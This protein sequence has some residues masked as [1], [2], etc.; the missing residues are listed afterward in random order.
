VTE[1]LGL[2]Y[3]NVAQLDALIDR[4]PGCPPFK[5]ETLRICGEE[6][7]LHFRDIILCIQE[8]IGNPEFVN[9]LVF[10]PE[11]HYVDVEK[12]IRIIDEMH[13]GDWW[14]TVQVCFNLCM[15]S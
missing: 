14:W 2:S 1:A 5:H 8:L 13:T 6:F 10:M 4:L 12:R 3:R 11:R 15:H 9:D 7:S